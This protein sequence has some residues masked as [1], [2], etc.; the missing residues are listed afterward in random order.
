MFESSELYQNIKQDSAHAATTLLSE[1]DTLTTPEQF[2]IREKF[3]S[4]APVEKLESLQAIKVPTLVMGQERDH[5][6]PLEFA[7]IL[8]KAIPNAQFKQLRSNAISPEQYA[9]DL[10]GFINEFVS[11]T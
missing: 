3:V 9:K 11:T 8:A 2:A 4:Q 5:T 1:F 6:H 10:M 7:K